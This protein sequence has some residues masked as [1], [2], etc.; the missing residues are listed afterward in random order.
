MTGW[1]L[2]TAAILTEVAGT[3]AL[4]FSD[5]FRQPL[6]TAV[7]AVGYALSFYLLSLTLKRLS[8]SLTYAVWSGLGTALVAAVGMVALHEAVTGRKLAGIALVIAGVVVLGL[9]GH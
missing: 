3:V 1:L 9:D 8:L 2:L 7:V 5:G 4:R 6:A